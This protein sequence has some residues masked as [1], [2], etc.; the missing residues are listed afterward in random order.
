MQAASWLFLTSLNLDVLNLMWV[1]AGGNTQTRR[2]FGAA[3][4]LPFTP[5]APDVFLRFLIERLPVRYLSSL[6]FN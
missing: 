5:H 3:A 4:A 6:S 1:R 2:L